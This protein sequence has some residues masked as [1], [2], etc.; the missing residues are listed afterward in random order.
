MS[1]D[2]FNQTQNTTCWEKNRIAFAYQIHRALEISRSHDLDDNHPFHQ[3]EQ[4]GTSFC[5]IPGQFLGVLCGALTAASLGLVVSAHLSDQFFF[6]LA[7][8]PEYRRTLKYTPNVYYIFA[9]LGAGIGFSSIGLFLSFAGLISESFYVFKKISQMAFLV[10]QRHPPGILFDEILHNTNGLLRW[11]TL[12]LSLSF[13]PFYYLFLNAGTFLDAFYIT[14]KKLYGE[15]NFSEHSLGR[16]LCFSLLGVPGLLMGHLI[17]CFN[18]LGALKQPFISGYTHHRQINQT[19]LRPS[20]DHFSGFKADLNF[21]LSTRPHWVQG[22]G[23]FLG[24]IVGM[25][26]NFFSFNISAFKYHFL[27]ACFQTALFDNA[28]SSWDLFQNDYP[29]QSSLQI[30]FSRSFLGAFL[31]RIMGELSGNFFAIYSLTHHLIDLSRANQFESTQLDDPNDLLVLN[32]SPELVFQLPGILLGGL[33]GWIGHQIISGL[34]QYQTLWHHA[35]AQRSDFPRS[36]EL[37]RVLLGLPGYFLGTV[38]GSF[39]YLHAIFEVTKL[40]HHQTIEQVLYA[41]PPRPLSISQQNKDYI[42]NASAEVESKFLSA[43]RDQDPLLDSPLDFNETTQADHGPCSPIFSKPLRPA[44]VIWMGEAL[45][46]F[47]AYFQVAFKKTVFEKIK[48]SL[49][50]CF[51]ISAAL[52]NYLGQLSGYTL[53]LV[54]LSIYFGLYKPLLKPIKNLFQLENNPIRLQ[55]TLISFWSLATGI[56]I[57]ILNHNT[58]AKLMTAYLAAA[59]M[60]GVALRTLIKNILRQ[61]TR[62]YVTQ[63]PTYQSVIRDQFPLGFQHEPLE[64]PPT[65][66]A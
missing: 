19:L 40:S 1:G 16:Y 59:G 66:P 44:A 22:L 34:L 15:P 50:Y 53:Q 55:S 49:P 5:A 7:P 18:L 23:W 56:G 41:S 20:T 64:N 29:Y 52:G 32:K 58:D 37:T 33:F 31:G 60:A 27:H 35:H 45:G 47:S 48:A 57:A 12:F 25:A 51:P 61:H 13:S 28:L 14:Q 65:P 26:V 9:C 21:I 11:P 3:L 43:K 17:G 38:L 54:L 30:L 10:G 63:A 62:D 42:F 39:A 36:Y 24:S 8:Q 2:R 6:H 4:H 46:Q